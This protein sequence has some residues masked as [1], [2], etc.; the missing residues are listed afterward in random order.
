MHHFLKGRVRPDLTGA[1][2]RIPA[3][4][5]EEPN[6]GSNKLWTEGYLV[7]NI[8]TRNRS[9]YVDTSQ[10]V[11]TY[12]QSLPTKTVAGTADP[13]PLRAYSVDNGPSNLPGGDTEGTRTHERDFEDLQRQF[14]RSGR[15]FSTPN[16][17]NN[18]NGMAM[19]PELP[20]RQ[21][22][23]GE[24][25]TGNSKT[26]NKNGKYPSQ[27]QQASMGTYCTS[28]ESNR[29][30]INSDGSHNL[31]RADGSL[32]LLTG[33]RRT[34]SNDREERIGQDRDRSSI[35]RR[36][37]GLDGNGRRQSA[38]AAAAESQDYAQ[39]GSSYSQ[40]NNRPP[41]SYATSFSNTSPPI[42]TS[43]YWT[44]FP[45]E[46][47]F[48]GPNGN[49]NKFQP[50]KPPKMGDF[51]DASSE[52]QY[53]AVVNGLGNLGISYGDSYL[54]A[55]DN[56]V[57]YFAEP[58]PAPDVSI[59]R[60]NNSMASS[61]SEYSIKSA[62]SRDSYGAKYED[63]KDPMGFP[64]GF[65]LETVGDAQSADSWSCWLTS[66]QTE[67]GYEEVL[68]VWQGENYTYA[69]MTFDT[70]CRGSNWVSLKTVRKLRAGLTRLARPAEFE[71]FNCE[72]LIAT[73]ET[74]LSFRKDR[75]AERSARFLVAPNEDVQ[76]EILLGAGDCRRFRIIPPPMLGL[77]PRRQ[78]KGMRTS[79]VLQ[80]SFC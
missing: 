46:G 65:E 58:G 73:F 56:D 3:P 14:Q 32:E 17:A 4:I 78:N 50:S 72:P 24:M 15:S 16:Y 26:K 66:S 63:N 7:A 53:G 28:A 41:N 48:W 59:P 31:R 38:V 1:Q 54:P 55:T 43:S 27:L 68:L 35:Q 47:G 71:A 21:Q 80:R 70:G 13:L 61:I 62:A 57:R 42:P 74:T 11:H 22:T 8:N 9:A 37:V 69:T 30:V 40:P 51:S 34:L 29:I 5:H 18:P 75:G 52:P 12:S 45:N 44:S 19:R 6:E 76:F 39:T 33:D 36:P 2:G 10:G 23:F 49:E 60:R 77:L 25:P 79:R 20:I 64:Q 67:E